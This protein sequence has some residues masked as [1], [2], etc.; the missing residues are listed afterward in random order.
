M[1]DAPDTPPAAPANRRPN[2]YAF[3]GAGLTKPGDEYL[4][5]DETVGSPPHWHPC[6]PGKD[7]AEFPQIVR[8]PLAYPLV[9]TTLAAAL[10]EIISIMQGGGNPAHEQIGRAHV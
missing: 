8:R 5:E 10:A 3:P 9:M 4:A 6:E 1:S 7:I 2:I